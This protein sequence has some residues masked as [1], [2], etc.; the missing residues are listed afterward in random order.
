MYNAAAILGAKK[1]SLSINKIFI[2]S[3]LSGIHIGF[4]LLFYT[5]SI[6]EK[7]LKFPIL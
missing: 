4:G 2:L 3:I 5:W 7:V 6:F 1:A